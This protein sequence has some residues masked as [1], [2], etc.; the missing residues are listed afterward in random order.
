MAKDLIATI[1]EKQVQIAKL[2]A[3]LDEA[4]ALLNGGAPSRGIIVSG[5]HR[6][7]RG[8][9]LAPRT[10]RR[11]RRA[12]FKPE[13]SVGLSVR[14]LK[15]EG[16]PLHAKDLVERIGKLGHKV[17][18]ITLVGNLSRL[19]KAERLFFRAGPNVFG[20]REWQKQ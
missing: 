3:E 12:V 17:N 1:K 20:L 10:S 13:S 2:K 11:S 8:S 14:V 4:R 18:K 6:Q 16:S 7:L 5:G 15:Q 9:S 19:V